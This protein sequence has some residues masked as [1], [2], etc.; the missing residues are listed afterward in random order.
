MQRRVPV[1]VHRVDV[2]LELDQLREKPGTSVWGALGPSSLLPVTGH[3][4]SWEQ[5]GRGRALTGPGALWG[6]RRG[7]WG[8]CG[9]LRSA[10]WGGG[11]CGG[12][13]R[14]LLHDV[15]VAVAGRQVQGGVVAPVHDVDARPPHDQHVDH[16]GAAL[17]AGP[18]QRAEAVVI[19]GGARRGVSPAPCAE[20][21]G[22][23]SRTP[24]TTGASRA[25]AGRRDSARGTAASA[26]GT[27]G[28][29]DRGRGVRLQ[30]PAPSQALGLL[31]RARTGPPLHAPCAARAGGG[32]AGP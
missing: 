26:W 6:P 12:A 20:A 19:P 18:V 7:H 23:W 10:L 1:L 11:C 29:G 22:G 5:R 28:R 21:G 9:V 4:G 16:V 24:G 15:A 32:D 14:Y 25:G 8:D 27:R 13:G 31:R 2:G 3:M 17:A 30:P